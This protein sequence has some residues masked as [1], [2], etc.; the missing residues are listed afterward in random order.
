VVVTFT[1]ITFNGHFSF[2]KNQKS[3]GAKSGLYGVLT[4]LDDEVFCPTPPPK[5]KACTRTVEWAGA[6]TQNRG[7]A[8]SAIVNVTATQYTSSVNGVSLPTD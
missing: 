7:S 8:R 4:V 1:N 2:K 5:K 3:Q 6:S